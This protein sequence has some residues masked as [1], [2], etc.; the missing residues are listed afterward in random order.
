MPM[1]THAGHA[2]PGLQPS[3]PGQA[4]MNALLWDT[5]VH[6][7]G[8]GGAVAGGGNGGGPSAGG[9]GATAQGGGQRSGSPMTKSASSP[10]C[11]QPSTWG[12]DPRLQRSPLST[13]ASPMKGGSKEEMKKRVHDLIAERAAAR[14]SSDNNGGGPSSSTTPP[15]KSGSDKSHS[16]PYGTAFSP[17][18]TARAAKEPPLKPDKAFLGGLGGLGKAPA[19]APAADDYMSDYISGQ[20]SG[21]SGASDPSHSDPVSDASSGNSASRPHAKAKRS[22]EWS[23]KAPTVSIDVA[24]AQ[25]RRAWHIGCSSAPLPQP[26][27]RPSPEPGR[28]PPR[29]RLPSRSASSLGS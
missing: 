23:T 2:P 14:R 1:L 27:L 10:S 15:R 21:R 6:T 18:S 17:E 24:S 4:V 29:P 19:P 8:Q 5:A 20:S 12:D 16:P 11:T 9:E 3:S 26:P 22:I 25:H 7:K 28:Q 13:D